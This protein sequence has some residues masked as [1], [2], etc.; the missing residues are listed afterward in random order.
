[1]CQSVRM[2]VKPHIPYAIA[3]GKISGNG[4][5]CYKKTCVNFS[6]DF[7]LHRF[8]AQCIIQ[9]LGL[10]HFI[11]NF[12]PYESVRR[13]DGALYLTCDYHLGSEL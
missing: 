12:L 13:W 4:M 6:I 8:S 2:Q 1:M 5:L 3:M 9:D 10:N 7:A 11:S